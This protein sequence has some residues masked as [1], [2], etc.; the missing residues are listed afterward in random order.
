VRHRFPLAFDQF[1]ILTKGA[2]NNST[3]TVVQ[4]AYR[5]AFQRQISV[6]L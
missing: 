5:E 3:V 6:A 4:V 1:F 2:P